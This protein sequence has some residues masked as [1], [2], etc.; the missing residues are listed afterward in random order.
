M[1]ARISLSI[2]QCLMSSE[3][4]SVISDWLPKMM[5]RHVSKKMT[6][7]QSDQDNDSD[8]SNFEYKHTKI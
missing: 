5:Y 4:R 6:K 7:V 3:Y 2:D 8:T 1:T